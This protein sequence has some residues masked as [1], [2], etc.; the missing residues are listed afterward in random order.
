MYFTTQLYKRSETVL[1][2]LKNC[3]NAHRNDIIYYGR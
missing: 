3:K 2:T 1:K